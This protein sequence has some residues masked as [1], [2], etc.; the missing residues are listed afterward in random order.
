M[1]SS[2]LPDHLADRRATDVQALGDTGLND[3]NIVLMEF[4]DALA[5]LLE[6]GMVFSR[7]RHARSLDRVDRRGSPELTGS[8]GVGAHR[9]RLVDRAQAGPGEPSDDRRDHIRVEVVAVVDEP[10][11][12]PLSQTDNAVSDG[13]SMLLDRKSTRLNSSHSSVSRMPSSA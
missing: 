4:E 2:D 3:L 12:H 8:E 7:R 5:V 10:A 13:S 1:C 9:T 11:A 6:R